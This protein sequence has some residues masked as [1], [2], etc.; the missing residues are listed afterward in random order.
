M[1]HSMTG[2]GRFTAEKGGLKVTTEIRSLNGKIS[3]LRLKSAIPLGS[4]EIE[5]R[6]TIMDVALRGKIDTS[7]TFEGDLPVQDSTFNTNLIK[8]HYKELKPIIDEL[9]IGQT[10]VLQSILRLPNIVNVQNDELGDSLW[11]LIEESI[12]GAIEKLQNFRA[13][14][15]MS[16]EKD[17]GQS[18]E[19]ISTLLKELDPHDE[20][21]TEGMRERMKQKLEEFMGKDNVDKNRFEQEVLYY[22]EKLD[23][24]EEKVRLNQ[25]CIYFLEEMKSDAPA[26]GKKLGF[27]CQE[28]GREINTLGAKAQ[29]TPIQRHVVNMK[30]ELE[31]VKEQLANT[32]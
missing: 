26:K 32:L 31:K 2:Y 13:T 3:D 8:N 28:M 21:R 27:I 7:I 15:G 4:K 20:A 10:D 29:W 25:H 1:I 23:I 22:L 24:N 5:V 17:L 9:E 16:I 14:E 30:N 11:M 19:I 12:G 18:V 6:K